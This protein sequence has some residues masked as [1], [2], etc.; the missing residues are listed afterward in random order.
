MRFARPDVIAAFCRW[1]LFI[2]FAHV[3]M[4]FEDPQEAFEF[5]QH[6]RKQLTREAQAKEGELSF[7]YVR[8]FSKEAHS[9]ALVAPP[10]AARRS[11]ARAAA[12]DMALAAACLPFRTEVASMARRVTAAF[13]SSAVVT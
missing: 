11:A 7:S 8:R 5:K 13:A 1:H 3:Y 4:F 2:G 6:C 10:V 12:A 9:Q